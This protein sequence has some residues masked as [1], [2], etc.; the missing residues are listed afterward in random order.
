MEETDV[1][2][3]TRR[4]ISNFLNVSIDEVIPTAKISKD[5]GADSL[6]RVELVLALEEEFDLEISNEA[7]EKFITVGDAVKYIEMNYIT[8]AI[9]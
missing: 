3:R 9:T 6:D 4:V 1:C 8:A 2:N 5:L 7:G